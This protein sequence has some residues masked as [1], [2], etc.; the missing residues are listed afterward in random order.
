[1]FPTLQ[2]NNKDRQPNATSLYGGFDLY[3]FLYLY[4]KDYL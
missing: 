2:I 3:K 1:M 4:L